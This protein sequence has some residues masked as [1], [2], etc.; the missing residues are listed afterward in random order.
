MRLDVLGDPRSFRLQLKDV[1]R[2]SG[3]LVD[4]SIVGFSYAEYAQKRSLPKWLFEL[5]QQMDLRGI[6][7]GKVFDQ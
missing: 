4:G 1:D 7:I 3:G 2:F 6:K 5:L